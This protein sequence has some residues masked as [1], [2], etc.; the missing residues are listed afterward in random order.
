MRVIVVCTSWTS[1][2]FSASPFDRRTLGLPPSQSSYCVAMDFFRPLSLVLSVILSLVAAQPG[3]DPHHGA[4][5]FYP[6]RRERGAPFAGNELLSTPAGSTVVTITR[7]SSKSS[8]RQST[9]PTTYISL[10]T[11]SIG[12]IPVTIIPVPIATICS[13][14]MNLNPVVSDSLPSS[15]SALLNSDIEPRL[16]AVATA[17]LRL[18]STGASKISAPIPTFTAYDGRGCSTLYTRT[19]SAICSTVLSG[20]GSIPA[21]VTDCQ[22]SVTFSTSTGSVPMPSP[23]TPNISTQQGDATGARLAYFV[24]AWYDLTDG[25]VPS[26]ALVRNCIQGKGG[27]ACNTAAESWSVVN[28]TTSIEIT[29]S[30]AFEGPVTGP[31]LLS[32]G[33]GLFTT[34]VP[35]STTAVLSIHTNITTATPTV[36]PSLS[37]SVIGA[38][39]PPI[40]GLTSTAASPLASTHTVVLESVSHTTVTVFQTLTSTIKHEITANR[41]TAVSGQSS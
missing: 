24:A 6:P 23:A 16:P 22:Q 21:S 7:T 10:G 36:V 34:H 13:R 37:R 19:S 8:T 31:A 40:N 32:L 18:N 27:E 41:N 26:R 20:F 2:S 11:S 12:P 28:Q 39:I 4:D 15:S 35:A 3:H 30:L 5:H 29:R 14:A 9:G 33:G 1:V 17:L 25:Q 38:S